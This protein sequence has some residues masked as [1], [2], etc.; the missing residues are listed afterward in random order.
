MSDKTRSSQE[1]LDALWVEHLY[2]ELTPEQE[3]EFQRLLAQNPALAEELAAQEAMLDAL[4]KLPAMDP[5]QHVVDEVLRESRRHLDTLKQRHESGFWTRFW[6]GVRPAIAMSAAAAIT[7][8]VGYYA[9]EHAVEPDKPGSRE[10]MEQEMRPVAEPALSP[11]NLGDQPQQAAPPSGLSPASQEREE[12]TGVRQREDAPSS[13]EASG[14]GGAPAGAMRGIGSAGTRSTAAAPEAPEAAPSPAPA[15]VPQQ[16]E[17]MQNADEKRAPANNS[18]DSILSS[19]TGDGSWQGKTG[20]ATQAAPSQPL[21]ERASKGSTGAGGG[22]GGAVMETSGLADQERETNGRTT[23]R[24][25]PSD[26]GGVVTG[27]PAPGYANAPHGPVPQV[28]EPTESPAKQ[29]SAIPAS[30]EFPMGQRLNTPEPNAQQESWV[31]RRDNGDTIVQQAFEALG[32]SPTDD[33]DVRKNVQMQAPAPS[34]EQP[35]QV[36]VS[37]TDSQKPTAQKKVEAEAEKKREEKAKAEV[38]EDKSLATEAQV[39]STPTAKDAGAAPADCGTAYGKVVS[40]VNQ[41][42]FNDAE[43][44][45]RSLEAGPCAR[46][47]S[48]PKREMVRA[49]IE[50]GQGQREKARTKLKALSDDPEMGK[51][52]EELLDSVEP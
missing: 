6:I 48:E 20:T 22:L 23:N 52:A 8:V 19:Q 24:E 36:A 21:R 26:T 40:L 37:A 34:A 12:P 7:L 15:Q 4:P 32:G 29:D 11:R 33:Q 47:I 9:V 27:V 2:G 39:A 5:P 38:A 14:E 30:N 13:P 18:V 3:A 50:L 28:A 1:Q 44:A 10:R 16:A 51:E 49:K 17:S 35:A 46:E 42:R 41:G 25:G 43:T 31:R 45:L